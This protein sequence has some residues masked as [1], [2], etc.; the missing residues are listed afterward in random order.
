MDREGEQAEVG[1]A[2]AAGG[3]SQEV[4]WGAAGFHVTAFDLLHPGLQHHIVNSLGW[5]ELRPFQE[6]VIPAALNGE[7]L[8]VLAPTAGGKTEAA[9]LPL[10]SRMLSEDWRGLSILYLC[11]IRA[12][13]NDLHIRL[14]RY[15]Q[16]VGRSCSFWHG[17]VSAS[18]RGRINRTPPDILLTTPESL[19][20]MLVSRKTDAAG[21]LGDVRAVIVDE[22]HA[23]AGDDRGWHLLSVLLRV[24]HLAGRE[25]QRIGLSA[26]VGNP[27]ELLTW[28]CSGGTAQRRIIA[29][30]A[31]AHRKAD[32]QLDFVGSLA[33]A[34]TVISRMHRGE[35]R[36][37]FV[38][39]RARAEAL[40]AEL[41]QLSVKTYVTH[42]SLSKDARAR[43]EAAFASETDCVIVAT[44]ALELGIDVGDL[45]RVIQ[46]DAPGRVASL[47]QRM[48]RTGRR[49][50]TVSNCLFLATDRQALLRAAGL[51]DLWLSGYVEPVVSPALPLHV[52]AQQ[53]MALTLQLGGLERTA[54]RDWIGAVPAFIQLDSNVI[55]EILQHMI[56]NE[57]LWEEGGLLWFGQRGE[58]QFG[59]RNFLELLSVFT[60]E[61]LFSVRHG[62]LELGFVHESSFAPRKDDLRVLL[63]GGRSWAVTHIDWHKRVAHVVPAEERGQSRWIGSGLL[64][65]YELCQAVRQILAGNQVCELWSRRARDELGRTR[66][67]MSWVRTG[68]TAIVAS[69]D[70]IV[71]WTFAGDR[72]N[73]LLSQ[74]LRQLAGVRAQSD[75]WVVRMDADVGPGTLAGAIDAIRHADL[76]AMSPEVSED[77]LE[78]LKFSACLPKRLAE[79][80]L[81]ARLNDPMALR[82]TMTEALRHV[83]V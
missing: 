32:V 3:P 26:T 54:W 50:G 52:F 21:L 7:H 80:V 23:F 12:L 77:M 28:L 37:A 34:A 9:I 67:E 4:P 74:G 20:V 29:P 25:F 18:Q 57:I 27:E 5:R 63:L 36:L 75:S 62:K 82:R 8:L 59:F 13:L 76:S 44:S 15:A 40:G 1:A 47:L 19:E 11:P 68:E 60:N 61:P 17:D 33:N 83:T 58:K 65:S 22:L 38:D 43:A 45:D 42:S 78:G 41:R 10:L 14:S 55:D 72:V 16:L 49:S 81:A 6:E 71:W 24:S 30:A 31:T 53:I 66:T 39:S 73:A 56:S 70:G 51:I 46:I 69:A 35:K 79:A 64:L 48:G 2:G